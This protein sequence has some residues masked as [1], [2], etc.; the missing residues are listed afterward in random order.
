REV[1]RALDVSE[2]RVKKLAPLFAERMGRLKLNG[3]F[4]S[5]SPLSRLVELEGLALGVTGKLGLWV[6]LQQAAESRLAGF[7][8]E[9]LEARA[10]SQQD[11]IEE[12]RREAAR[13]A[14]SG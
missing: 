12:Q 4:F 11:G 13:I 1:M 10:R 2:D 7:D 6:A 3:S 9:A 8:L 5:Y 14:L